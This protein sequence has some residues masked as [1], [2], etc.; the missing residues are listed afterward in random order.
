MLVV[1]H[2]KEGK[3]HGVQLLVYYLS[4][5]LPPTKQRYPH[6]QKLAYVVYMMGKNL[7]HYFVCHSFMVVASSPL[8]SM[9]NNLDAT[10]RMSLWAITLGPWKITYQR[11]SA[12]N[13]QVL[14]DFIAEWTKT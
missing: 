8:A 10:G 2:A 3:K 13:S 5:L 6:F 7:P 11:Q 9:L 1:E 12:I 4:E 14:P